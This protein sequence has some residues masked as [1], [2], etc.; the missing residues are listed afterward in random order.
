MVVRRRRNWEWNRAREINLPGIRAPGQPAHHGTWEPLGCRGIYIVFLSDRYQVPCESLPRWDMK[1]STDLRPPRKK[2]GNR[3]GAIGVP[4]SRRSLHHDWGGNS[5][6]EVLMLPGGSHRAW[7][8]ANPMPSSSGGK[9]L[10][11]AFGLG[12]RWAQP[13][14]P[15]SLSPNYSFN[16]PWFYADRTCMLQL[17]QSQRIELSK[18]VKLQPNWIW[19]NHIQSH[20]IFVKNET[21]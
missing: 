13:H 7:R 16:L 11:V 8:I 19:I 6:K 14:N 1:T 10:P 12:S 21:I 17:D 5:P 9:S 18:T 3:L 15:I 20:S 2:R 4:K